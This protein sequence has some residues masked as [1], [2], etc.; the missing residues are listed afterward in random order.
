[1]RPSRGRP[2]D[3]CVQKAPDP[4]M[5]GASSDR[6]QCVV[7]V[8]SAAP[9][10][11]PDAPPTEPPRAA[12]MTSRAS[13]LPDELLARQVARGS[14]RAFTAIYQR[15]HQPLYRYCR[16]LLRNDVDAQDA[17]QSTFVSALAA[18]QRNQRQA[19]LRPWLF[20]IA[21]NEAISLLRR[22]RRDGEPPALPAPPAP[23]TPDEQLQARARLR[24]LVADLSQLP[25]RTRGA[26]LLRE[27]SG[28]SHAEIALALDIS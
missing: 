19:P 23:P 18:L 27:L 22:A 24:L 26:L 6:Y 3:P 16:A 11:P 10:T 7:H 17:L 5:A 15:Y 2:A 21:H 12:R 8:S 28:L 13:A 9:R 20:R 1:M 25:D 4:V 14:E